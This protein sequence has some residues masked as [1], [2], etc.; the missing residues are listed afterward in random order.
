MYPSMA[1]AATNKRDGRDSMI[2]KRHLHGARMASRYK[3]AG[4]SLIELLVCITIIAI[5]MGLYLP[6]LSKAMRKAKD[7]A[8]KEAMHQDHIGQLADNANIVRRKNEPPPTREECRDAFRTMMDTGKD[9]EAYTKLLYEVHS[10]DEFR[11]YWHTLINPDNT[12]PLVFD[13]TQL[14]AVDED[15][16]VYHLQTLYV[17]QPR[18]GGGMFPMGWSF[19]STDLDDTTSGEI[20]GQVLFS[21]GHVEHIRYPEEYPMTPTVAELSHRFMQAQP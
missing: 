15:D 19:I 16:N 14:I 20:G 9:E 13:G 4:F 2:P 17:L 12:E 5:L 8:S 1:R 10:E 6:V 11:A 18:P 7:V 3:Y 21:D